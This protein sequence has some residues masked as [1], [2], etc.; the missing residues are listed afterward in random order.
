MSNAKYIKELE[1]LITEELLPAYI[2]SQRRRGLN[3]NASPIITKLINIMKL[4]REIPILLQ[5]RPH[6]K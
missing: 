5:S 6:E 2:E 4:K 3:P 1:D